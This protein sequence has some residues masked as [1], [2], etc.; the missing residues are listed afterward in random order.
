MKTITRIITLFFMLFMSILGISLLFGHTSVI[1]KDWIDYARFFRD[2]SLL[3]MLG[4][5]VLFAFLWFF[6][7]ALENVLT[8]SKR[9][10]VVFL[11]LFL[12]ALGLHYTWLK[13]YS[14]NSYIDMDDVVSNAFLLIG[15]DY[16]SFTPVNY[17][18]VY[19]NNIP[20][21]FIARKIM[22]M[23]SLNEW[24]SAVRGLQIMNLIIMQGIFTLIYGVV[25]KLSNPKAAV[26]SALVF[27][28]FFPFTGYVFYVYSDIPATFMFLLSIYLYLSVRNKSW[29]LVLVLVSALSLNIGNILRPVG[30]ILFIAVVLHM[31]ITKPFK[32]AL[33]QALLFAVFYFIPLF[34]QDHFLISRGIIESPIVEDANLNKLR[35]ERGLCKSTSFGNDQETPGFHSIPCDQAWDSVDFEVINDRYVD[36]IQ[37]NLSK[38]DE[39]L[40]ALQ[41]MYTKFIYQWGD[42]M[43]ETDIMNQM[44]EKNSNFGNITP[45]F[46]HIR[47]LMDS[48]GI[49]KI[50]I[51]W[52]HI[53]WF[54]MIIILLLQT[55]WLKSSNSLLLKLII[56]GYIGFYLL[57]EISPHYGFI[58]LPYFIILFSI[59][60]ESIY[61]RRIKRTW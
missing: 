47:T 17:L 31:L 34:N 3:K 10:I 4:A 33:L 13:I 39:P 6:R 50:I 49:E 54:L 56:L 9:E 23:F 57:W 1:M 15:K 11:V 36:M 44:T 41:F 51:S 27:L 35:T 25:R 59:G 16:V 14:I 20:M 18:Y 40:L 2:S 19:T 46:L 12:M 26:F 58:T 22:V 30:I 53:F 28:L 61:D 45:E 37:S 43:F 38:I 55:F 24:T 7:S 42:G 5:S 29:S 8:S 32:R 48:F 52:T 21:T 60:F